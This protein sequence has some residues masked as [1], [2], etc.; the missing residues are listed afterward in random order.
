MDV[1]MRLFVQVKNVG[2][3]V[4]AHAGEEVARGVPP[5][6][7]GQELPRS[8]PKKQVSDGASDARPLP[9]DEAE[10]VRELAGVLPLHVSAE[11]PGVLR[12]G[13]VVEEASKP[14]AFNRSS[15]HRRGG[16]VGGGRLGSDR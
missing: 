2:G 4:K 1:G 9:A 10:L 16:R 7:I 11:E 15:D 13:E 8:G 3:V 14:P 6:G 5:L 12:L